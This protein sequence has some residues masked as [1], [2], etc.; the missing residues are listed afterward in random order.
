MMS[1]TSVKVLR[2]KCGRVLIRPQRNMFPFQRSLGRRPCL[3]PPFPDPK[4]GMHAW[5][6]RTVLPLPELCRQIPLLLSETE[7]QPSWHFSAPV[8]PSQ[9]SDGP[10]CYSTAAASPSA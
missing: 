2:F 5:S 10:S 7:S 6:C 1:V 4:P 8:P 3:W 9:L